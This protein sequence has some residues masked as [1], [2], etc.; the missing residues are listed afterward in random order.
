MQFIRSSGRFIWRVFRRSI[1]AIILL[2]FTRLDA[3][4]QIIA[5]H[6]TSQ[7]HSS[8]A[9][10]IELISGFDLYLAGIIVLFAILYTFYDVDR[11]VTRNPKI[12]KQLK[13]FYSQSGEMLLRNVTNDSEHAQLAADMI[14]FYR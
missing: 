7:W 3:Y 9:P 1:A 2:L 10:Y 4:S 5:P 14:E 11:E 13:R 6:L 8:L 12:G